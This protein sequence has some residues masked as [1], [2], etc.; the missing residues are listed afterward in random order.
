MAI[1]SC[2]KCDNSSFESRENS[3]R[4][5][6]YKLMFVQCSSCGAVV[7]VLDYKNIGTLISE[8]NQAIKKIHLIPNRCDHAVYWVGKC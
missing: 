2:P 6:N 3:P 7:G 4:N 1:S 8:Q 5:S